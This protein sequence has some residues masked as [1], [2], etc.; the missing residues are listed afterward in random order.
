MSSSASTCR[1]DFWNKLYVTHYT[2]IWQCPTI[3]TRR[4]PNTFHLLCYFV[5][6]WF[7][8]FGAFLGLWQKV[9]LRLV[10]VLVGHIVKRVRLTVGGHPRDGS[11][12]RQEGVLAAGVLQFGLLLAADT[13]ARFVAVSGGKDNKYLW[14]IQSFWM[15]LRKFVSIQARVVVLILENGCLAVVDGCGQHSGDQ[16][17]EHDEHLH[18]CGKLFGK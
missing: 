1:I 11:A 10:A 4:F 16:H 14:T 2:S 6:T 18:V 12:H 15:N 8:S 3:K 13:V 5:Y 17:G 7:I 9:R